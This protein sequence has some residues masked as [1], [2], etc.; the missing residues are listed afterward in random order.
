MPRRAARRATRR[1]RG[2]RAARGRAAQLV[3]GE[4]LEVR[5]ERG[6][7]VRLLGEPLH[8]AA[9][10]DAQDLLELAE[11]CGWHR[12]RVAA[13]EFP[14]ARFTGANTL[15]VPSRRCA[16]SS[17]SSRRSRSFRPLLAAT[18][19]RAA[20]GRADLGGEQS[21]APRSPTPTNSE[22]GCHEIRLWDVA[23]RSDRR[24]ASHCFVQTSTGSGVA[25]VIATGGRALWLTYTGG[26]IRE[27]SLW[28]KGA[29]TRSARRIAFVAADVDGPAPVV[30][31]R[32]WEGSLPYA[33]GSK[34]VVL[35]PNGSRRFTLTAPDRV[36]S[37][38]AHSR[39]Y[40]AVLA[41]GDVLTISPDRHGAPR[42]RVRAGRRRRKRCSPHRAHRQDAERPRDPQR[43]LDPDRS[44]SPGARASSGYSRGDRR[45]TGPDANSG[46]SG[47]ANGHD[48]L[49]RT[50]AAALPGAARPPRDRATRSGRTLGF[51]AWGSSARSV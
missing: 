48:T 19:A 37:L 46:S 24:L 42:A 4:L 51:T 32:V 7:V 33:I 40:A 8:A 36:V 21:P 41:S 47:S 17:F 25:G 12:R 22:P 15:A 45:P 30:L 11:V 3:V 44:R 16:G 9:L 43:R 18:R 27:W 6:D 5:L 31:G 1:S 26:N 10:A 20:G 13:A 2:A 23:S 14:H 50:L 38:S 29:R 28:T 35:A 49:F 34:I 39:G